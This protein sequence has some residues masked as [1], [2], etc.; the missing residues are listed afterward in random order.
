MYRIRLILPVFLAL[1]VL[2][3]ACSG[4]N[5]D[6][7]QSTEPYSAEVISMQETSVTENSSPSELSEPEQAL[8]TAEPV[9]AAPAEPSLKG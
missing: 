8:S 4:I 9:S 5:A 1:C 6:V 2:L 7:P 3:S